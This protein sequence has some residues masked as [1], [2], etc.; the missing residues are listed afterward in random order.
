[1]ERDGTNRS[2]AQIT[3]FDAATFNAD[4]TISLSCSTYQGN[5]DGIVLMATKVTTIH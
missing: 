4:A 5:A 1:M 2:Y 3:V